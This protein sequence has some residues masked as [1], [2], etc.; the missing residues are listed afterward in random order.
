MNQRDPHECP[1]K[2]RLLDEY[3]AAT[4]AIDLLHS[5]LTEMSLADVAR[6]QNSI[7]EAKRA[8]QAAWE[9]LEIHIK[10]HGC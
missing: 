8:S 1:E 9:A 5:R 7:E 2:A 4:S 3:S 6:L 10:K